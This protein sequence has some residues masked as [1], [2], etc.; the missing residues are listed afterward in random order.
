VGVVV[1]GRAGSRQESR[2]FLGVGVWREAEGG[3]ARAR[4]WGCEPGGPSQPGGRLHP[5]AVPPGA[6]L[7]FLGTCLGTV[8][9]GAGW[10]AVGRRELRGGGDR[11]ILFF[12]ERRAVGRRGR[13]GE[14]NNYI[15]GVSSPP[16]NPGRNWAYHPPA[17]MTVPPDSLWAP[18]TAAGTCGG[19]GG[20]GRGRDEERRASESIG[21]GPGRRPKHPHASAP[22]RPAKRR[23]GLVRGQA[24]APQAKLRR[25]PLH[26]GK[27][28]VQLWAGPG[29]ARPEARTL[30]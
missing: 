25:R 30:G 19:V 5:P 6:R 9:W 11:R 8:A 7:T 18:A 27:A 23:A 29:A 10:W 13:G 1:V 16:A 14:A 21:R 26:P 4:G 15:G 20:K 17:A 12:F 24:T 3:S 28:G 22:A 2:F